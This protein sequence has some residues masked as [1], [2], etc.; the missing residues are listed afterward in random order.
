MSDAVPD[1]IL[2]IWFQ[3]I[4][5]VIELSSEVVEN[6]WL[7][8]AFW[9]TIKYIYSLCPGD[10]IYIRLLFPHNIYLLKTEQEAAG[11]SRTE[12]SFVK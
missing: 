4:P 3:P 8:S 5:V 7:F 1:S 11:R 2:C 10:C 12:D 6:I 9:K